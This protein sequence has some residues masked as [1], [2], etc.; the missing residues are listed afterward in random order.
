VSL[1]GT[2][3]GALAVVLFLLLAAGVFYGIAYHAVAFAARL[4]WAVGIAVA[5]LLLG[6]LCAFLTFLRKSLASSRAT[7]EFWGRDSL[8]RK[9]PGLATLVSVLVVVLVAILLM[10]TISDLLHTKARCVLYTLPPDG[11]GVRRE[12]PPQELMPKLM[13]YYAWHAI[14][15]IPALN[16]WTSFNVGPPLVSEQPLAGVLVLLFRLILVTAGIRIVND[17]L[18]LRK[19]QQQTAAPSPRTEGPAIP[20]SVASESADPRPDG[21]SGPGQ[22]DR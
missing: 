1:L 19:A 13:H 12:V 17:W 10:E 7:D 3:A 20:A 15:S 14:D 16:V 8:A 11:D 9:R 22:P 4:H 2:V 6:G 21:T 18:A 5:V